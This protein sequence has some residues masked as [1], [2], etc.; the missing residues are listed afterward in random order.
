MKDPKTTQEGFELEIQI[1]ELESKIAPGQ[2]T[3]LPL[4]GGSGSGHGR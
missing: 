4:G 2:E 3:V 1:E